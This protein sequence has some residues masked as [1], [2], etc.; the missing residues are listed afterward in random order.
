MVGEGYPISQDMNKNV[1]DA[2][3][4]AFI[5]YLREGTSHEAFELDAAGTPTL[6]DRPATASPEHNE[7]I[8][9]E[10]ISE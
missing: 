2:E 3:R 9:Q 5:D 4:Q 6:S 7:R 1:S 8:I 10:D